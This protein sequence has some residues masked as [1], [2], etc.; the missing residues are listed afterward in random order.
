M[1]APLTTDL[2]GPEVNFRDTIVRQKEGR[3]EIGAQGGRE[4]ERTP[5][6]LQ[7]SAS[8]FGPLGA[9]PNAELVLRANELLRLLFTSSS[10]LFLTSNY[11]FKIEA[12]MKRGG[13]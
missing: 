3:A 7:S 9:A 4:G 6:F 11:D 8:S 13:R 1:K 5:L 2:I 10:T 12:K